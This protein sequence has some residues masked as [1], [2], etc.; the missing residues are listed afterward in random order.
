LNDK[1]RVISP[2]FKEKIGSKNHVYFYFIGLNCTL[3]R[4]VDEL[5][6]NIVFTCLSGNEIYIKIE[7]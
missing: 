1:I 7:N 4:I 3:S 5:L 2:V 6:K